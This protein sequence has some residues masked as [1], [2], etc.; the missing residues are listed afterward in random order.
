MRGRSARLW[1]S[2]QRHHANLLPMS[3]TMS[4]SRILHQRDS[5][6]TQSGQAGQLGE[7]L[8]QVDI[9]TKRLLQSDARIE[10]QLQALSADAAA[11]AQAGRDALDGSGDVEA[12]HGG[13]RGGAA[14]LPSP[15][16]GA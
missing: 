6:E 4:F 5:K 9:L 10:T 2:A 3:T 7:L 15:F 13:A 11:D 8:Q 12:P 14:N 16:G 1:W